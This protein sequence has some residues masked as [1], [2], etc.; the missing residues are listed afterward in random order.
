MNPLLARRAA[1]LRRHPPRAR[2]GRR[3]T[4]CW[5]TPKPRSNARSAPAVPADYDALVRRARRG[6]GAAAPRLGRRRAPATPWPTRP[7]CA[8]PTTR[9]CP[10]HRV[11]H[12][13][14]RRTSACTPSTRPWRPAR[15]GA[16]APARAR[17]WP[18]RCATS[19]CRGAELQG[20]AR[21]RYA[22][23]QD[24]AAALSQRFGEHVLDAT[25]AFALT[26]APSELD[27][28]PEDVRR[29]RA[30]GRGG[31]RA[32]RL[33]ADAAVPCYFPVMQ[34]AHDRPLRERCTAPTSP[35]PARSA[36]PS[37]TTAR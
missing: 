11:L 5:P 21:E 34:Y 37:S 10:R 31:R 1:R 20:A 2:R 35:A 12:A 26:S 18:T 9:T 16:L 29:G 23:I 4:C 24:A 19:C 17:R 33:Q 36:R 6:R 30:R 15:R 25:D 8:P 32:R 13:A 7:S 14:G 3:W 28:V 27:G 22:A